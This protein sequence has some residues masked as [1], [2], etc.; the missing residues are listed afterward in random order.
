[1]HVLQLQLEWLSKISPMT[2]KCTT[3][4]PAARTLSTSSPRRAKLAERIE[5]AIKKWLS[6]PFAAHAMRIW[7]RAFTLTDPLREKAA[8]DAKRVKKARNL[9]IVLCRLEIPVTH[10]NRP[11]D[12]KQRMS[13]ARC[14]RWRMRD[15]T[16]RGPQCLS[17]PV[18]ESG[19]STRFGVRVSGQDS[20]YKKQIQSYFL[21]KISFLK[22]IF[23]KHF[24]KI[25][26]RALWSCSA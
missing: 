25:Q 17:V 24:G 9:N 1:M 8:T 26:K 20:A 11:S 4:A 3:S 15:A 10:A 18:D 12:R 22:Q 13:T 6:V 2:S 23:H 7:L 19:S 21:T 5:G 16:W 14:K